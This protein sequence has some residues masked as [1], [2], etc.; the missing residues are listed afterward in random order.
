MATLVPPPLP[1]KAEPRWPADVLLSG[2]RVHR[3]QARLRIGIDHP[4]GKPILSTSGRRASDESRASVPHQHRKR[5]RMWS[6][7][8][9][10]AEPTSAKVQDAA[11]A[12]IYQCANDSPLLLQNTANCVN[13]M[14]LVSAGE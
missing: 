5:H 7:C 8:K 2:H 4:F 12:G 11:M 1:K 3:A 13:G 10:G 9:R 6:H 14:P